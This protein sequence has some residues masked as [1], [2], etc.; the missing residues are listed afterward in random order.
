MGGER[1]SRSSGRREG[2]NPKGLNK[3]EKRDGPEEDRITQN[4]VTL[5]KFAT[6]AYY[7]PGWS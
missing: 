7:S 5:Q 6:K 4:F 1:K 2:D 3:R